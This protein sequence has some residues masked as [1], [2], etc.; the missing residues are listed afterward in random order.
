M[1]KQNYNC[2]ITTNIS[3]KEAIDAINNIPYGGRRTLRV[4]PQI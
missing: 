1:E 4:L 3:A 2:I